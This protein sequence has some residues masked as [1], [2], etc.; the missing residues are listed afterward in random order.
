MD[1]VLEKLYER[2]AGLLHDTHEI[3]LYRDSNKKMVNWTQTPI[4]L[5]QVL[6][7]WFNHS[8]QNKKADC[9]ETF[10]KVRREEILYILRNWELGEA[11]HSQSVK[12]WHALF[13]YFIEEE[14]EN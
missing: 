7:A 5:E 4:S 8:R 9:W 2:I 10:I 13:Q 3:E 11:L 1:N 14:E 12:V 6:L